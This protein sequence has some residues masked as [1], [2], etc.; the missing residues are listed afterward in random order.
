MDCPISMHL[1]RLA[2][3]ELGIGV[4]GLEAI[5]HKVDHGQLDERLR[6]QD[7]LFPV[8]A[9]PTALAQPSKR[10]LH[11]C[12]ESAASPGPF[13]AVRTPH[14]DHFPMGIVLD[15][16]IEGEVVVLAVRRTLSDLAIGWPC[17]RAN[18]AA[19]A[20]ASSTPQPSPAP[21]AATPCYRPRYGVCGHRRFWHCPARVARRRRWYR[22]TGCPRWPWCVARK[23]FPGCGPFCAA[24][25][26]WCPGCRCG[27]SGR[28]SAR[29]YSWA[30]SPWAYSATGSRGQDV[31]VAHRQTSRRS[32][33][34]GRPPVEPGKWGAIKAH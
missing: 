29:L 13:L 3:M 22:P 15:P 12:S 9:K 10:P 14:D 31:E 18:K 21:P 16:L 19:A 30:G 20:L 33:L 6:R 17:S 24:S 4:L 26:G 2:I 25:R 7:A 11:G 32:V 34:R 1:R 5:E 28:S 23:A 8:L 27:A